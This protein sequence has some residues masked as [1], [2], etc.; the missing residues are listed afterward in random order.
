MNFNVTKTAKDILKLAK[1]NSPALLT[2]CSVVAMGSA[3]V[4]TGVG[5]VKAI[6]KAKEME[7]EMDHVPGKKDYIKACWKCYIPA[8]AMGTVSAACAIGAQKINS[9]RAAAL[10]AAYTLTDTALK[11]FKEKAVEVVGEKKVEQIEDKVAEKQIEKK[12]FSSVDESLIPV[13]GGTTLCFDSISARYF[14]SDHD[15]ILKRLNDFNFQ[16]MAEEYLSINDWYMVL[17]LEGMGEPIGSKLCWKAEDGQLKIRFTSKLSDT[18][19]P[20]L[21]IDYQVLPNELPWA[22]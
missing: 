3:C 8:V 11:E 10:A 17:G 7:R 15:Y 22:Y 9:S 13:I 2:A 18:G 12:P 14:Y 5:T 21:V 1:K 4:L 20:C 6:D 16:L 19:K